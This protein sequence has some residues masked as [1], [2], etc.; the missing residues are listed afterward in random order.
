VGCRS[1]WLLVSLTAC[2]CALAGCG[3]AKR[4]APPPRLP[5]ALAQRLAREAD[6]VRTRELAVR[7]Q[8]DVVAAINAGRVPAPLQEELQ[9]RA[10]AVVDR[11]SRARTFAAWLRRR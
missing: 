8:L 2:S 11:P 7:L 9:S 10:N 6:G 5:P 4:D 1:R 3:S